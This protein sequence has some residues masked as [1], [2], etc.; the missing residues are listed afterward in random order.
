[1]SKEYKIIYFYSELCSG[2]KMMTPI[3]DKLINEGISIIK[4]NIQTNEGQ[5][6][7]ILYDVYM[8]PCI[9]FIEIHR[10]IGAVEEEILR[11]G[12]FKE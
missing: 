12:I 9:L 1:M 8:I 4:I 11:D 2:C 6:L 10:I 7:A 3:I 5:K